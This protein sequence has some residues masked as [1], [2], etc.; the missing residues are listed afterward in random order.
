[1]G[2]HFETAGT[3]N[4]PVDRHQ[5]LLLQV[6][7]GTSD[8]NIRFTDLCHLLHRMGFAERTKGGHHLFTA[9]GIEDRINLQRDGN[10][11]KVY[12]VRQVRAVIVKYR[13]EGR[14]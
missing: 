11:A 12:Q 5:K 4:P 13:L 7:Q 10:K 9:P 8:A 6:L 3:Y 14:T 1:M 2:V